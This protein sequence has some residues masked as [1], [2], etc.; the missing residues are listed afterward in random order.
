MLLTHRSK[1]NAE[2][3]CPAANATYRDKIAPLVRS[4]TCYSASS[5]SNY[6]TV[7][8]FHFATNSISSEVSFRQRR[9]DSGSVFSNFDGLSA[10]NSCSDIPFDPKLRNCI[11]LAGYSVDSLR[12]VASGLSRNKFR[13]VDEVTSPF[14]LVGTRE[15][16]ASSTTLHQTLRLEMV[17]ALVSETANSCEGDSQSVKV[18]AV[19]DAGTSPIN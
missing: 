12:T 11:K 17:E 3:A 6:V 2:S 9:A 7:L 4:R 14:D 15:S 10:K 19:S 13:V 18:E 8:G 1:P 5:K 16:R